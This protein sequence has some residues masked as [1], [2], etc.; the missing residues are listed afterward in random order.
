MKQEFSQICPAVHF[1]EPMSR[2]TSIRIGG[3]AEVFAYP[4]TIDE[5]EAVAAFAKK[6]K[7]PLLAMGAGSNLLVRDKGV[8]GIVVHLSQGFS[9]MEVEGEQEGK[10]V[11]YA[12]AGVGLPR[13][14]DFAAEEG[15]TGLEA[16]SGVPGNVGGGLVMNAGTHEGDISQTVL[17]VA[18]M[19]KDGK[20]TTWQ[21]EKIK[22]S[23]R[24]S[25][26]PR[27]AIIL[28]ARFGLTRQASE[29]V[30]G[31]IQKHRAYRLETQPLNVPNIG[32][33][34]KNYE[35]GKKK[36]FAAKM[37]E[38]A[39]L[40]DVRVGGARISPKHANWIVNEGGATAKDVIALIGLMKDKVK[41][42]FGISMET[43][44]RV[45]GEE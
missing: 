3:P 11:L 36:M 7:L 21:K 1:E 29:L 4:K 35:E 16:V 27:G 22:Y 8:R 24:E 44:V 23:Y 18:F 43:E 32:S 2:H 9:K 19:D 42:K 38:E 31:K 34:F 17:S 15:L 10:V 13:L 39:G 25:H 6:A 5:L 28:S 33:V 37:I 45:V 20:V 41:D 26:F 12:E 40:K 14:V 30:R